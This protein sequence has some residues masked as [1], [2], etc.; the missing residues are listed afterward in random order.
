M[1]IINNHCPPPRWF[2]VVYRK[3]PVW[4]APRP[5]WAGDE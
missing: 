5:A 3:P 1:P 2:N 4:I